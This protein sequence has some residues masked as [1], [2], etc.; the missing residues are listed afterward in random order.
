VL[1]PAA[2]IIVSLLVAVAGGCSLPRPTQ[3]TAIPVAPSSATPSATDKLASP[4]A[5]PSLPRVPVGL[6]MMPGA[7]AADRDTLEPGVIGR[8][9]VTAV[10]PRVYS[11]LIA[12]LPKAGFAIWRRFPGGSVAVIR[13]TTPNGTSMQLALVGEGKRARRTRIDLVL[14]DGR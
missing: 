3:E 4:G 9:S 12:A 7:K 8:W 2:R 1:R 10:P 13:F 14:P 5:T 6:P 11:Y